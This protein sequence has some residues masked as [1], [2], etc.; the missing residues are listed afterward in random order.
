MYET[1]KEVNQQLRTD[2]HES[3][4]LFSEAYGDMSNYAQRRSEAT[5][6]DSADE[7]FGQLILV[8]EAQQSVIQSVDADTNINMHS[9]SDVLRETREAREGESSYSLL[10]G[11]FMGPLLGTKIGSAIEPPPEEEQGR[12]W[13]SRSRAKFIT[14]I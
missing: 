12:V 9:Y 5:S 10:G 13:K 3:P 11:L 1:F 6:S 7:I 2:R 8:D 4:E 14:P